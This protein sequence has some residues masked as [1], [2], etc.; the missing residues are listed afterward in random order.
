MLGRNAPPL[1]KPTVEWGWAVGTGPGQLAD[2]SLWLWVP[3]PGRGPAEL[4]KQEEPLHGCSLSQPA[5][6]GAARPQ[7]TVACPSGCLYSTLRPSLGP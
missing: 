7:G 5:G 6:P 2:A 1:H 3:E 4:W